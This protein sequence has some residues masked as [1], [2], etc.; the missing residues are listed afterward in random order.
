MY[1]FF[2]RTIVTIHDLLYFD[3]PELF[4]AR[5]RAL[6]KFATRITIGRVDM[7]HTVSAY[8]SSRIAYRFHSSSDKVFVVSNGVSSEFLTPI[9]KEF[10]QKKVFSKFNIKSY[11]LLVGRFDIRKNHSYALDL[12]YNLPRDYNL[13]FIGS[14][15]GFKKNIAEK[16]KEKGLAER[17]LVVENL[18]NK[19]LVH[20]YNAACL[21]LFPSL[22]EGFGI[23]P[24]EAAA[25]YTPVLCAENTAMAEFE[26]LEESLMDFADENIVLYRLKKLMTED[27]DTRHRKA[28]YVKRNFQWKLL[29]QLFFD[30]LFMI[31]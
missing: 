20:F 8:T 3:F 13:V 28:T 30:N 6:L 5:N 15:A 7:I 11:I 2:G 21:F 18:S 27:Y 19:E 29:S 14:D 12:L 24:L 22:A 23:P 1:G 9:S 26:F 25:L 31:K 16:I 4:P 10:S 17:V